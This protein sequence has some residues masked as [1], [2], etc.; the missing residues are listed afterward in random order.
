[1]GIIADWPVIVEDSDETR[2]VLRMILDGGDR[3]RHRRRR[4][5]RALLPPW[6]RTAVGGRVDVRMPNMDITFQRVLRDDP[7]WASVPVVIFSAFPPQ[8]TGGALSS[9]PRATRIPTCSW[10]RSRARGPPGAR[11]ARLRGV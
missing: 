4:P 1:M 3:D 9:C 7:R 2:S 10:A 8:D 6:R 5:R 11:V